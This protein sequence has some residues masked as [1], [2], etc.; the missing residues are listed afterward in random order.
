MTAQRLF[1]WRR[2]NM[3]NNRFSSTHG[4][5]QSFPEHIYPPRIILELLV[6]GI[7]SLY[8]T[9][10]Y[11]APASTGG[12]SI[13]GS[14]DGSYV[15]IVSTSGSYSGI[16]PGTVA[17]SNGSFVY[18]NVSYSFTYL[19]TV[20]DVTS[21]TAGQTTRSISTLGLLHSTAYADT[22]GFST[23]TE[24]T[25]ES[26]CSFSA[27]YMASPIVAM[28]VSNNQANSDPS[29]EI[30]APIAPVNDTNKLAAA[31]WLGLGVCAD[32]VTPVL[33]KLAAYPGNY[34]LAISNDATRY[35][36]A[37]A[38]HLF[39]LQQDGSWQKTTNVTLS[40]SS[41]AGYAYLQ[42]FDWA[43]FT[44]P[45]G[46][47][48]V[49]VTVTLAPTSNPTQKNSVTFKVRPPP[50]V[51]V[52]G[53]NANR[54]SWGNNFLGTMQLVRPTDFVIPVNYGVSHLTASLDNTV[55]T[56]GRLDYLVQVLDSVLTNVVEDPNSGPG[57]DWAFTRYDVVCHSQG[58]VLTRML[59]TKIPSFG[60][61]PFIG[62]ANMYRGRFRRIITIGSP[63]NGSLL[64]HYLLQLRNS[65]SAWYRTLPY[66]L[67]EIL[68]DK[69][70]PFGQQIAEINN[71]AYSIDERAKFRLIQCTIDSGNAPGLLSPVV[72]HLVG[73]SDPILVLN[74]GP[75]FAS[76]G[77]FVLPSGSDGVVDFDSQGA[78]N[79]GPG[80]IISYLDNYNIVHADSFPL[81]FGV[82][83]GHSETT[84]APV[85]DEV[86]SL[87]NGP[88]NEFGQFKVPPILPHD[89][90]VSID[91]VVP[92]IESA[93][94]I[95]LIAGTFDLSYHFQL[96]PLPSKPAQG[97]I[98]WFTEAFTT[99]GVSTDGIT[100]IVNTNDSGA[101]TVTVADGVIGDV[102]LYASYSSTNNTLIVA[103]PRLVTSRPGGTVMNSIYMA[104]SSTTLSI[105]DSVSP[106]MWA[107][108]TNGLQR[109]LYIPIGQIA[110]T[111]SN[112][113]IAS[114]DSAGTITLKSF[115]DATVTASYNG[116]T[117]SIAISSVI[118]S[119]SNLTGY[120]TA[121]GFF[122]LSYMGSYM[123]TN[124]IQASTDLRDWV[125][126]STLQ[127]TNGFVV[128]TDSQSAT[129]QRRFYR[130]LIK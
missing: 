61:Q 118:P 59:C 1:G 75:S 79:S 89:L 23:Y 66:I 90:Q 126:L 60:T 44:V 72:F 97:A 58:G 117:A 129:F 119:I 21:T 29:D 39:V 24:S 36:G 122:Q 105:G 11:S 120:M 85:A 30:D 16:P 28:R 18:N 26:T 46:S 77:Q 109:Q 49:N 63:H 73:L 123:M 83:P 108:Y 82:L 124:V 98:S 48:E 67:G 45:S 70:D 50:V 113:N 14:C 130:V 43:D 13:A 103:Q 100:L 125:S 107:T 91:S 81:L 78:G 86:V 9:L 94:I 57:K 69:F 65:F 106:D 116:F 128:F 8:T 53:Y 76:R 102:V 17:H 115:G 74:P 114:V 101:V 37:I 7:L 19:A 112:T 52:H 84:Y 80:S 111:S 41:A 121:N 88:T 51:L 47:N 62:Q 27:S 56:C 42:G 10:L 33:L 3:D 110:Y 35:N 95:A 40:S 38:D 32:G 55:N 31:T 99:N 4:A 96:S 5:R 127:N 87:L 22:Y 71:L 93:N 104:P 68:Q 92:T 54:E 34:S 6:F 20:S 25:I 12:Y 2:H 64:L 15:I